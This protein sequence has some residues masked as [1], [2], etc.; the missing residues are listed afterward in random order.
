MPL[1]GVASAPVSEEDVEDIRIRL[2]PSFPVEF[3]Q[4]SAQD[5]VSAGR[6]AMP[7]GLVPVEVSRGRS[8][9][10]RLKTWGK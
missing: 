5:T 6:A 8:W 7:L 3:T 1:G 2:T 9:A 4:G 10:I